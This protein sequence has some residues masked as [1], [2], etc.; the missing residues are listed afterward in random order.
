LHV[1]FEVI[2]FAQRP[3]GVRR[4]VAD[5][6]A[7]FYD[8]GIGWRAVIVTVRLGKETLELGVAAGCIV[9]VGALKSD[10]NVGRVR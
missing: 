5:L 8:P 1:S 9:S 3:A 6:L 4:G 7:E 10:M 2:R